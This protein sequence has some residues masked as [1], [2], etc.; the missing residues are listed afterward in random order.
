MLFKADRR[1]EKSNSHL[2]SNQHLET[3][4]LMRE[5]SKD[6]YLKPGM[7]ESGRY[8]E[9]KNKDKNKK[10][11]SPAVIHKINILQNLNS[12]DT[13]EVGLSSH[14]FRLSARQ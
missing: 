13:K 4:G 6:E 5:A 7:M 9:E 12:S 14:N 10:G 1:H 3:P 11:K 2:R 8:E